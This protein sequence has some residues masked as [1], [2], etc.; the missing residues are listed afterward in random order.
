MKNE[1]R[2]FL[3]SEIDSDYS[4]VFNYL[5]ISCCT[6]KLFE[7]PVERDLYIYGRPVP[8]IFD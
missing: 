2:L 8:H 5:F 6:K 4:N 7:F 1:T 3:E